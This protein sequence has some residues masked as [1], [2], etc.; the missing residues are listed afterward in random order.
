MQERDILRREKSSLQTLLIKVRAHTRPTGNALLRLFAWSGEVAAKTT[1]STVV[2]HVRIVEEGR[3]SL[4]V[5]CC[6]VYVV[7]RGIC[8]VEWGC[9]RRRRMRSS[10]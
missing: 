2:S 6:I 1:R 8:C 7:W 3:D 9:V 4:R 10:G 5:L